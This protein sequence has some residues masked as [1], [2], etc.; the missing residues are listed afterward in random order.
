MII[1]THSHYDDDAFDEDR[2]ELLS[3]LQEAGI[4]KAITVCASVE[5]LE[6]APAL[7]EAYPFLYLGAGI[8]PDDAGKVSSEVIEKIHALAK[9]P[10]TVV[11]GEIG[12]DYYWHKEEAEHRIQQGVFAAQMEIAK[13][14]GLPFMV[15]SRDACQD[16]LRMCREA[17]ARGGEPGIIHCYSYS[18]EA[19]KEFLAMGFYLGIGGVVTYKNGRKLK[20]VVEKA[21][22]T[23]LLLETDC[24]YLSPVPFRGKRNSSRYL[25]YV[26]EEIAALKGI[27]KEEVEKTTWANAHRIMP[28]LGNTPEGKA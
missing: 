7:A 14:E 23:Q 24:P 18:W 8:H 22:L 11:I 17:I 21:P 3:S 1:D 19:A 12:L 5:S 15:H 4:Q 20:E 6:S 9:L 13:E 27:S 25:P 28:K 10:K 2:G 26:V 16:T